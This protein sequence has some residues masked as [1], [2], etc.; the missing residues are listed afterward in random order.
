MTAAYGVETAFGDFSLSDVQASD[1][2]VEGDGS[3]NTLPVYSDTPQ[4]SMD[5]PYS[6]YSN[7]MGTVGD[8]IQNLPAIARSAGTA[9]G[10]AQYKIQQ[11]QRQFSGAR[12]AAANNNGIATW[13]AYA[14]TTDKM[15]IGLAVIGIIIA[16]EK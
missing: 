6:G 1:V 5:S 16:L 3:P 10:T 14:S 7:I 11:A 9:I 15:M 12:N 8:T 2:L 13:W 4:S